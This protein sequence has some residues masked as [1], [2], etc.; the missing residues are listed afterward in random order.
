MVGHTRT[1]CMI[2]ITIIGPIGILGDD[3]VTKYRTQGILT[4]HHLLVIKTILIQ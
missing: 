4:L 2:F 3:C 1:T